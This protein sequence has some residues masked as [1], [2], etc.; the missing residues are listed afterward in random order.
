MGPQLAQRMNGRSGRAQNLVKVK[1][2]RQD[3][4]C[5]KDITARVL[6]S[7]CIY[8]VQEVS[9]HIPIYAVCIALA[10][11]PTAHLLHDRVLG[12]EVLVWLGAL[13]SA[14]ALLPS[15]LMC[16]PSYTPVLCSR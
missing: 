11:I 8:R 4:T 9:P 1:V 3:N 13:P 7:N 14:R 10:S 5:I 15:L 6:C 16:R 12:V 2:S